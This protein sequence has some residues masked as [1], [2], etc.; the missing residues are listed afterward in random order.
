VADARVRAQLEA[1]QAELPKLEA[2]LA[3]WPEVSPERRT[4]ESERASVS[5]E[6]EQVEADLVIARSREIDLRDDLDRRAFRTIALARWWSSGA[7]PV[8]LVGAVVAGIKLA[9]WSLDHVN[10]PIFAA[11]YG[12]WLLAAPLVVNGARWLRALL[13]NQSAR[14]ARLERDLRVQQLSNRAPR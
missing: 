2:D 14:K 10:W 7:I 3:Q 1:V 6:L 9:Y 5:G 12:P 8:V 11:R 13:F 4:L